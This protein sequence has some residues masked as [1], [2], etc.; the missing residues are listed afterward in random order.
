M[1][2]LVSNHLNQGWATIYVRGPHCAFLGASRARFQ[3]KKLIYSLKFGLRGP[4]VA[5]GPYV[6]PS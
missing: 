6:A 1:V 2:T 4:D 3:S 5:R